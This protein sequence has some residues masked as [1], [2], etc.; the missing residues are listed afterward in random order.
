[1]ANPK[2]KR[3]RPAIIQE[4]LDAFAALKAIVGY[5]PANPAYTVVNGTNAKTLMDGQQTTEAQAKAA[6]DAARDNSCAAEWAF[7]D[8]MLGA[9]DQVKAQFGSNSNELQGLGLK[10]KSEYKSKAKA[11]AATP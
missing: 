1:M 10:K 11:K 8:Y 5:A 2:T 9:K 4:D 7:H 3:L 6:A